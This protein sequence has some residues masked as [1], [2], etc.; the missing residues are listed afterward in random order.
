MIQRIYRRINCFFILT[1][2]MSQCL[3]AQEPSRIGTTAAS[4]LEF[5]FGSAGSSMGDAYV[6][7]ANDL[8]SIYWNPAGLTQLRRGEAMFMYQPWVVDINSTFTGVGLKVGNL[9]TF[10]IGLINVDYGEMDVTTLDFQEGTGERFTA[11]DF[12]A[13]VSFARR[14]VDWFSFGASGKII[15]SRIWHTSATAIAMDM[16]LIINT[17]FFSPSE[18]NKNGLR[19]GMSISNYGTRMKYDGVDL[20]NPIDILPGEAGNF[21]DT[22]GQF[23]AQEWELPL[24]FRVG[25]AITPIA[26]G[27]Q[28]VILAVDAL[29]PNNNAESVN[30]GGE[31]RW[32][33]AGFG[34]VALRGGY[35]A[36]F[37]PESQYGLTLGVGITTYLLNNRGLRLE[38]G[39]REIGILGSSSNFSINLLF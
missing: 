28:R 11:N 16:G 10:A 3:I 8:S 1:L 26:T 32:M 20:L 14:L 39:Y 36:L 18:G 24:I 6:S 2:V 37:L 12:A 31:Y 25:T 27:S 38:Y 34:E 9:G 17:R 5:G 29:H 33:G 15:G 19:I 13:S 4:F 21:R 7:V 22:P 35:K 30:I 23:Q